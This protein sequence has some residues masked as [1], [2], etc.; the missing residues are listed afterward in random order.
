[1]WIINITS[2][3]ATTDVAAT[4]AAVA[5]AVTSTVIY[6]IGYAGHFMRLYTFKWYH[7]S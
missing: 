2:T 5:A 3:T 1:M 6:T 7:L 4:T